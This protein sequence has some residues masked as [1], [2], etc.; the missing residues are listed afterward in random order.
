ME[1]QLQAEELSG[2]KGICTKKAARMSRYLRNIVFYD[3]SEMTSTGRPV[4]GI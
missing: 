4:H 1:S 2:R 3:L